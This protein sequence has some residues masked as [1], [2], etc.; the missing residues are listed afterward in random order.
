MDSRLLDINEATASCM[1]IIKGA[2]DE[3][4]ALFR[5]W[6]AECM[7]QIGPNIAWRENCEITPKDGSIRKPKNHVGS[8][9]IGL[10]NSLNQEL[11]YNF[12]PLSTA[13]IH[14]DRFEI[15]DN[16]SNTTASGRVDMSEDAYYYH[17]GTNGSSVDHMKL[18]YM[19]MPTD[20]DGMPLIPENNLTAYKMFCRWQWSMREDI[21][22]A[23]IAQ[24]YDMWLREFGMARG[25]NKMP[26]VHRAT[27]AFK[28]YLSMVSAPK[29]D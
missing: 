21:S 19:A 11:K 14:V 18:S 16:L 13:R 8:L 9:E 15:R 6:V 5:A 17:L 1:A 4:R 20:R 3:D 12:I 24:S 10:Y 22:Q 27:Q 25:K 2:T 7:N 28:R 23:S 26:D 29:F